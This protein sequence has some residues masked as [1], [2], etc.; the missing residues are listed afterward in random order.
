MLVR[1]AVHLKVVL[2][3]FYRA[4]FNRN[5][6]F[7]VFLKRLFVCLSVWPFFQSTDALDLGLMTLFFLHYHECPPTF[8]LQY[9]FFFLKINSFHSSMITFFFSRKNVRGW[10][11]LSSYNVSRVLWFISRP[12]GHSIRQSIPNFL[13]LSLQ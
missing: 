9:V 3:A 6:F 7:D 4:F 2:K 1:L 11:R 10:H 12:I 8:I 13:R 5:S